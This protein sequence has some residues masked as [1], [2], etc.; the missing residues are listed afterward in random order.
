MYYLLLIP[1]LFALVI[2]FRAVAAPSP[3][4]RIA[5][6]QEGKDTPP[7]L[8]EGTTKASA[9]TEGRSEKKETAEE[10]SFSELSA[11]LPSQEEKQTLLC[12]AARYAPDAFESFIDVSYPTLS[13]IA[14]TRI[15]GKSLFLELEADTDFLP[16][17]CAVQMDVPDAS[18]TPQV[19][20]PF[21]Y[22]DGQFDGQYRAIAMLDALE[23]VLSQGGQLKRGVTM[24]FLHSDEDIPQVLEDLQSEEKTYA[25]VLCEGGHIAQFGRNKKNRIAA[26]GVGVR[27]RARFSMHSA[28]EDAQSA[29]SRDSALHML[30]QAVLYLEDPPFPA[31]LDSASRLFAKSALYENGFFSRI[32]AMNPRVFAPIV[33]K[34]LRKQGGESCVRNKV[35]VTALQA[36][37][38]QDAC[39]ESSAQINCILAPHESVIRFEK[40]LR[41]RIDDKRIALKLE[42]SDEPHL[43]ADTSSFGYKAV[44]KAIALSFPNTNAAPVA[45]IEAPL[46]KALR[47]LCAC[48]L[49]FSPYAEDL[50]ATAQCTFFE[51]FFLQLC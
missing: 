36:Q 29:Q 22:A 35:A 17:V 50:G 44:Q 12:C 10:E 39:F 6:L 5:P 8:P 32:L 38:G 7:A 42:E 51:N 28:S 33:L 31:K 19:R 30:A 25:C 46:A 3:H 37:H 49:A 40:K 45:M 20:N 15:V 21:F 34:I 1:L 13:R 4:V 48:T 18:V 43:Y 24:V 11:L 27:T 23:N 47:P 9:L 14:K 26:V 2:V 16:V 41:R